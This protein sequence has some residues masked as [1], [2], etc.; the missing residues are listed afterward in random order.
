[1]LSRAARR[2]ERHGHFDQALADHGAA[3][4]AA[5]ANASLYLGRGRA[6]AAKGEFAKAALDFEAALNLEPAASGALMNLGSLS[7]GKGQYAQAAER[8][9]KV[10][11]AN[12]SS[13]Y[14]LLWRH[15]A[16]VRAVGA[17]G[18]QRDAAVQELARDNLRITEKSVHAQLVEFYLGRGDESELRKA[19]GNLVQSCQAH[20]FLAQHHLFTGNQPQAAHLLRAVAKQCPALL[21]ETW[22]ARLELGRLAQ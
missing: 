10:V 11:E 4:A 7:I 12:S 1:L 15:V 9:G 6:W 20:Y 13:P 16:R 14:V 8:I 17:D 3:V 19:G 5:P 18:V 22:A 2:H 21:P